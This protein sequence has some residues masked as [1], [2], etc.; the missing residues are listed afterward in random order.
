MLQGKVTAFVLLRGDCVYHRVS[1]LA[2][3]P[4]FPPFPPPKTVRLSASGG[5]EGGGRRID[6]LVSY[7]AKD[8]QLRSTTPSNMI[9]PIRSKVS[10]QE[11]CLMFLYPF[12]SR[13]N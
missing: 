8:D 3:N 10:L 6:G 7:A 1:Q 5:G 12:I 4:L 9:D 2:C 13:D 11:L